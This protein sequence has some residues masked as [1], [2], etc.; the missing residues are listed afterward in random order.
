MNCKS[1]YPY[2]YHYYDDKVGNAPLHSAV[3]SGNHS[4]V[5]KLLENETININIQ[6]ENGDTPLID[7]YRC[8]NRDSAIKMRQ[9]LQIHV[10]L[11]NRHVP[12]QCLVNIDNMMQ[13]N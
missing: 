8:K 10:P 4:I 11:N 3:M 1:D 5:D 7:T 12:I 2:Y 9:K 6:D 13:Q